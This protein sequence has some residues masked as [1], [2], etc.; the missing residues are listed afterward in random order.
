MT[1]RPQCDPD[2]Q[3]HRWV[4]GQ[5]YGITGEYA[6]ERWDQCSACDTIRRLQWRHGQKWAT[7][8]YEEGI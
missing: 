4:I 6:Y 7:I 1:D 3:R 8:T 2:R 5:T